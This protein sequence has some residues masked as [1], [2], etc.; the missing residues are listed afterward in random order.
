METADLRWGR[1]KRG[2]GKPIKAGGLREMPL[3]NVHSFLRVRRRVRSEAR[4]PSRGSAGGPERRD[5]EEG[6]AG[7]GT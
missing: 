2:E 3:G 6:G 7:D 5:E 1:E 4:G